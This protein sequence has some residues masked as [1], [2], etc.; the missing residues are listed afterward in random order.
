MPSGVSWAIS[1]RPESGD[2]GDMPNLAESMSGTMATYPFAA[3]LSPIVGSQSVS[4]KISWMT[5]MPGAASFRSGYATYARRES[6]VRWIH[7][8]SPW[9]VTASSG[10]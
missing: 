5:M 9:V 4:P 7:T 3:S 10:L 6:E 2:G 1:F 8:H